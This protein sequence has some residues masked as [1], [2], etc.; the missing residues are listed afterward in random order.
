VVAKHLARTE[1]VRV[2]LVIS[3]I[4]G[5]RTGGQ[6]KNNR[7]LDFKGIAAATLASAKSLLQDWLPGG[8]FQGDEYVVRNPLRNDQHPGSFKIN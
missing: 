3:K 2:T 1:A 6:M 8:K 7:A 4:R 5:K